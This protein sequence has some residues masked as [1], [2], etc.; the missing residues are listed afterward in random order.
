M[1]R[2]AN[3]F[4]V[5]IATC[6]AVAVLL[7]ACGNFPLA[8]GPS[9]EWV[10]GTPGSEGN[11]DGLGTAARF[12]GG[13]RLH[14]DRDGGVLVVDTYA[15]TVRHID[16]QGHVTTLAGRSGV[17]AYQ[18]GASSAARFDQP[19]DA[20]RAP[21]GTVYV[22]DAGNSLVRAIR[23][24][25]TV[26]TIAGVPGQS[27]DT[28]GPRGVGQLDHPDVIALDGQGRLWTLEQYSGHLRIVGADGSVATWKQPDG[29]CTPSGIRAIAASPDGAIWITDGKKFGH[30]TPTGYTPLPSCKTADAPD[31]AKAVNDAA[32]A[33][34]RVPPEPGPVAALAGSVPFIGAA[35]AS[36]NDANAE[37]SDTR[38]D[39]DYIALAFDG[40]GQM[41]AATARS[42]VTVGADGKPG[43]TVQIAQPTLHR[44]RS[45]DRD[46]TSLAIDGSGRR[47]VTTGSGE[48]VL[49]AAPDG[50][51]LAYAGGSNRS[52]ARL[53][54]DPVDAKAA[55]LPGS[56]DDDF[57]VAA[58][59]TIYYVDRLD[60]AIYRIAPDGKGELWAGAPGD[61]GREDGPRLSARFRYPS[62]LALD[63]A[64]NL[65]V[66]DSGNALI[67]R[68]DPRGN[69]Q[70]VSG[71]V[72]DETRVDGPFAQATFWRPR[73]LR[74][75]RDGRLYVLDDSPYVAGRGASI[76]RL[77]FSAGTVTTVAREAQQYKIPREDVERF[78]ASRR[79]PGSY[80][81]LAIGPQGQL[82]VLSRDVIW[83]IDPATGAHRIHFLPGPWPAA[84][85]AYYGALANAKSRDEEDR[86]TNNLI[87]CDWTWCMPDRIAAD[88]SGN[89]YVSDSGNHTVLRIDAKGDAAVIAGQ[90]GARGN[91][92]GALPGALNRPSGMAV[93]PQGDLFVEVGEAGIVRIRA[94]GAAAAQVPVAAATSEGAVAANARQ[95]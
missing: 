47:L 8:G 68:I 28:D 24:D 54:P 25:G 6:A 29:D 45:D 42:I 73:Y 33:A 95:P 14:A 84:E 53:V 15:S 3:G 92:P 19:G 67:R 41:I 51:L 89:V 59:G 16:A 44:G 85:H 64:G 17:R 90:L 20:V 61:K 74:F 75:D 88:A 1:I 46:L 86:L 52:D 58:D 77:D 31:D 10:A 83:R 91:R 50:R 36:R 39:P 62:G 63:A 26:A 65:F 37:A 48:V 80:E 35:P 30:A 27:G 94:P 9:L 38:D 78:V 71:K 82:Y 4:G 49:Q 40:T 13:L 12:A 5:R 11:L 66:A 72:S 87:R 55:P 69:V 79:R 81:D 70:T 23:P 34:M 60:D 32:A 43:V 7:S 22:A 21:D 57:A 2:N 18:D 56:V 93:T 76:R